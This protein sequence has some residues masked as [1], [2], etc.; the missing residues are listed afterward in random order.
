MRDGGQRY[1]A[2]VQFLLF[3]NQACVSYGKILRPRSYSTDRVYIFLYERQ[4][5]LID[6]ILYATVNI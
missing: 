2:V 1:E 5:S 3:I 4:T 6:S